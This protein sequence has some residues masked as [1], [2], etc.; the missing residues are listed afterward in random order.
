[1]Y[2]PE[3]ESIVREHLDLQKVAALVDERLSEVF[4]TAPLRPADFACAIGSD[5]NQATSVFDLLA[6]K[7]LLQRTEMV[8]CV[9][10]HTLVAAA[11]FRRAMDDEDDFE[12]STC[13]RRF[14]RNTAPITVYRMAA[15]VA[16]RP[17]PELEADRGI[18]GA[19]FVFRRHGR[20]WEITYQ[21]KTALMRDI[22]APPPSGTRT[23][24][25]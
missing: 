19:A 1:M 23:A 17:R 4:S 6:Q 22:A 5:I 14:R 3:S 8:E 25:G 12:C 16:A 7:G 15:K 24:S 9:H 20:E 2:F 11:A 13:S 18:A 10:C 21:G